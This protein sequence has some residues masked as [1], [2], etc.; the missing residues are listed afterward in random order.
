MY[1]AIA[2]APDVLE[3]SSSSRPTTQGVAA[4]LAFDGAT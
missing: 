2:F 3:W 4:R 1:K